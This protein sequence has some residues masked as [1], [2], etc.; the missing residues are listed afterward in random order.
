MNGA[1]T[2]DQVLKMN[3]RDKLNLAEKA[4]RNNAWTQ[5]TLG[6]MDFLPTTQ[7]GNT[8]GRKRTQSE[9]Q[10]TATKTR[11]STQ[12]II[13]KGKLVKQQMIQ[14]AR[15]GMVKKKKKIDNTQVTLPEKWKI[16]MKTNKK[17][18]TKGNSTNNKKSNK[19]MCPFRRYAGI[20]HDACRICDEGGLL[21]ECHTCRVACHT[22]CGNMPINVQEHNVI[23]R[24]DECIEEDGPTKCSFAIYAVKTEGTRQ[25]MVKK[26]LS[27]CAN[28]YDDVYSES[29][30]DTERGRTVGTIRNT[31]EQIQVFILNV[32]KCKVVSVHPD[33]HCLR[34]SIGKNHNL[35]PGEVIKY[36]RNKCRKMQQQN[37]KMKIESDDGWYTKT[38]NRPAEWDKI[39]SNTICECNRRE[40]GGINEVQLWAMIIQ[41][42]VTILDTKYTMA[43]SYEPDG[44]TL[45][46]RMKME[47][48]R[49]R[50][51][52]MTRNGKKPEYILY[53]GIHHYNGI[54][55]SV[56]CDEIQNIDRQQ[57]VQK[58]KEHDSDTK[59]VPSSKITVANKHEIT[60]TKQKKREHDM[61][62]DEPQRQT[63]KTFT[64]D[65]QTGNDTVTQTEQ[66]S[67][68][69]NF[70][71]VEL[72]QNNL[73]KR[74]N[75]TEIETR[76]RRKHKT[77]QHE[78]T[79]TVKSNLE[80]SEKQFKKRKQNN[81][82]K[83]DEEERRKKWKSDNIRK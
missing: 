20:R 42:T 8:K 18:V 78:T 81:T 12:L 16:D 39:K 74:G 57:T 28:K 5:Q 23:W 10:Q 35:H 1:I 49:T 45:P 59:V 13:V 29:H 26:K 77:T 75:N 14:P 37:K 33:G 52:N 11:V 24:C 66:K 43:T 76:P 2:I 27:H 80:I 53:D 36:M 71:N 6:E 40:W 3:F 58:Q 44:T 62:L 34:R 68:I 82:E 21:V 31:P 54:I 32:I 72:A 19:N 79:T 50:H 64:Q 48:L 41:Q 56:I 7:K 15:K 69:I 67:T 30:N 70:Q 4:N 61:A 22:K 51:Y 83:Q 17:D 60:G 47:D 38:A 25:R 63:R 55:S 73:N 65:T 46:L 9:V